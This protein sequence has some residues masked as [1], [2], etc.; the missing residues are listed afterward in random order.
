VA[1]G[2]LSVVV[3]MWT[4]VVRRRTRAKIVA[5]ARETGD[6]ELPPRSVPYGVAIAV[7]AVCVLSPQLLQQ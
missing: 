5:G 6:A 4:F 2:V 7:A 3:L 1:G